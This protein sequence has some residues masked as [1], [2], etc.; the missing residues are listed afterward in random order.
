MTKSISVLHFL[1]D[2]PKKNPCF[3][4]GNDY[5]ALG[6][7]EIVYFALRCG[8]LYCLA[9][10]EQNTVYSVSSHTFTIRPAYD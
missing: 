1:Q 9:K 4:K 8:R 5:E 10:S 7:I 2:Y 3:F 6:E